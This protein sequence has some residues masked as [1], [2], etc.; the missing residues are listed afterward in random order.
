V[1]LTPPSGATRVAGVL[2]I[3]APTGREA[4]T[5]AVGLFQNIPNKVG[6]MLSLDVSREQFS[7]LTLMRNALPGAT[8]HFTVGK[9]HAS[10]SRPIVSWT[11]SQSN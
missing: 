5:G 3:F 6:A 10:E 1:L 2:S 4:H 7:D 9:R 8:V 11:I